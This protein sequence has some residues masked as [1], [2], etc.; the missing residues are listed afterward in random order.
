MKPSWVTWEC[1]PEGTGDEFACYRLQTMICSLGVR[2]ALTQKDRF[3]T[4]ERISA[5]QVPSENSSRPVAGD[6]ESTEDQAD[7]GGQVGELD[8]RVF[9]PLYSRADRRGVRKLVRISKQSFDIAGGVHFGKDDVG[10]SA[11]DQGVKL[12][13]TSSGSG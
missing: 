5:L 1:T 12:G 3:L 2:G 6:P 11:G 10:A 7:R 9:A 4:C 13:C 8:A